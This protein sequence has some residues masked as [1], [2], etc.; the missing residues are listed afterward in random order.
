MLETTKSYTDKHFD[1]RILQENHRE[2]RHTMRTIANAMP[3]S[4]VTM[5]FHPL[6]ISASKKLRG[7]DGRFSWKGLNF[8]TLL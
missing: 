3:K 6:K 4:E 1:V 8:L 5:N 7:V 2:S